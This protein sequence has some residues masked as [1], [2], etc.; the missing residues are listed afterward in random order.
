MSVCAHIWKILHACTYRW[1]CKH[2]RPKQELRLSSVSTLK[3]ASV[4]ISLSIYICLC[5]SLHQ[6]HP[7]PLSGHWARIST[8]SVC[9]CPATA[10]RQVTSAEQVEAAAMWSSD[11]TQDR[12]GTGQWPKE[13]QSGE[14]ARQLVCVS[15]FMEYAFTPAVN[16]GLVPP[17]H[18]HLEFLVTVEGNVHVSSFTLFSQTE[19]I[20]QKLRLSKLTNRYV[21]TIT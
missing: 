3:T 6:S 4:S 9:L 12:H 5:E 21:S 18:H 1:V 8:V 7:D 19:P 10:D 2:T 20:V 14:A 17:H 13:A 16:L 15:M 11:R